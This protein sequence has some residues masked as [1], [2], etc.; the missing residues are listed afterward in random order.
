MQS[1]KSGTLHWGSGDVHSKNGMVTVLQSLSAI[2]VA[3]ASAMNN[4]D[5]VPVELPYLQDHKTLTLH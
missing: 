2:N 4:N 3:N 5:Q 1:S